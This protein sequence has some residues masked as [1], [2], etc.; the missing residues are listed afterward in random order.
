MSLYPDITRDLTLQSFKITMTFNATVLACEYWS[1]TG[2]SVR[3]RKCC[4]ENKSYDL[5]EGASGLMSCYLLF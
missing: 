4:S 5:S 3:R 2:L 1:V